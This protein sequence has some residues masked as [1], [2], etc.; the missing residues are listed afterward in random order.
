MSRTICSNCSER[1]ECNCF[2][3]GRTVGRMAALECPAC[4]G[5]GRNVLTGA[6]CDL[7]EGK[8][9]LSQEQVDRYCRV[10]RAQNPIT[11]IEERAKERKPYRVPELRHLSLESRVVDAARAWWRIEDH[12]A[13]WELTLSRK[14]T[15]DLSELTP[16]ECRDLLSLIVQQR[17]GIAR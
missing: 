1:E 7:C 15:S 4:T 6:S 8:G 9:G 14:A 12:I 17:K 16:R 3:E 5:D 11:G 2:I 10:T 13:A